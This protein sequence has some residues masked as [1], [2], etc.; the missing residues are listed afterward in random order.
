[1]AKR[2]RLVIGC[3]V[4]SLT[5]LTLSVAQNELGLSYIETL[6][7]GNAMLFVLILAFLPWFVTGEGWISLW[8]QRPKD[9]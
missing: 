1:M 6:L 4:A 2:W 8:R 3:V 5:G 9:K 7:L